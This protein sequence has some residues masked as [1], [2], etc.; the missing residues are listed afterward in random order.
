[1]LQCAAGM[2]RNV[3]R[4]RLWADGVLKLRSSPRRGLRHAERLFLQGGGTPSAREALDADADKGAKDGT[5]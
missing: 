4:N 5:E 2:L 3:W 1:M